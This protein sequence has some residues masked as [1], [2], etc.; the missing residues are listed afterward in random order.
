MPRDRHRGG[1]DKCRLERPSQRGLNLSRFS[2]NPD[3][4]S[5]R[6]LNRRLTKKADFC[7]TSAAVPGHL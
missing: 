5:A 3:H 6:R 7:P 4:D 2:D 1:P